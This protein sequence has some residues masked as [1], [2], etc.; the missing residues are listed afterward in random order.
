MLYPAI[1]SSV[2]RNYFDLTVAG[3]LLRLMPTAGDREQALQLGPHGPIELTFRV[4]GGREE[5]SDSAANRLT[6]SALRLPRVNA[7]CFF[8]G[9][10]SRHT[11]YQYP[12]ASVSLRRFVFL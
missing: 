6:I 10:F 5:P 11:S 8:Q 7:R 1:W 2:L 4:T 3:S 9:V 12:D